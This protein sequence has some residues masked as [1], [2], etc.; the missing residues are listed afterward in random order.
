MHLVEYIKEKL[1][2]NKNFDGTPS[3]YDEDFDWTKLTLD[4]VDD[5]Y[6]DTPKPPKKI[7]TSSGKYFQWFRWWVMLTMKSMSKAELFYKSGLLNSPNDRPASHATQFAKLSRDNIIVYNT[8][9]RKLEA[10]PMSKW[11]V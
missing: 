11:D 10:M 9:T 2:I 1:V 6:A 8:K 5:K 3:I 7:S 4:D